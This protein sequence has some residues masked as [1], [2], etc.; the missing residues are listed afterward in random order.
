MLVIYGK[1]RQCGHNTQTCICGMVWRLNGTKWAIIWNSMLGL[2]PRFPCLLSR[3]TEGKDQSHIYRLWWCSYKWFPLPP[4]FFPVVFLRFLLFLLLP[5]RTY[6]HTVTRKNLG[7]FCRDCVHFHRWDTQQLYVSAGG[8]FGR[9]RGSTSRGTS[10]PHPRPPPPLSQLSTDLQI[11]DKLWQMGSGK[12]FLHTHVI[13]AIILV[14]PSSL[15]SAPCV[16]W[17]G[18]Y[19]C[20]EV[21]EG[22]ANLTWGACTLLFI[23]CLQW[24]FAAVVVEGWGICLVIG[25]VPC[26]GVAGALQDL[27][28]ALCQA[29]DQ[30]TGLRDRAQSM[31]ATGSGWTR[32][33]GKCAHDSTDLFT[34]DRKHKSADVEQLGDIRNATWEL[35]THE[36]WYTVHTAEFYV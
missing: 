29:Q 27:R 21:T 18:S 7:P 24:G 26:G 2:K 20:E 25:S 9:V 14:F 16:Y 6:S 12:W 35:S 5:E 30:I 19:Q 13:S 34:L 8:E 33:F 32:K 28:C 22:N 1:L 15:H 11:T 36:I 23:L 17:E 4:A 3:G 10:P 31:E